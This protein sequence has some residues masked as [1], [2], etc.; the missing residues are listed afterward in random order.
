VDILEV[1][2]RL[3]PHAR[4]SLSMAA[5]GNRYEHLRTI[6][7][8]PVSFLPLS[9]DN[10]MRGETFG[11]EGWAKWQVTSWWR[12]SPGGRVLHKELDFAPD[13]SRLVGL[14]QAGNDPKWQALLGSAMDLGAT[15]RLDLQWRYVDE[16]PAPRLPSYLELNANLSWHATPT[17]DL[18][19]A[20]VNLLHSAH[21]EYP[22]PGGVSLR[23]ALLVQLKWQP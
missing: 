6:E 23:R 21:Q 3:R 10:L 12:L 1:G 13:A 2:L 18:G 16:L 19:L 20:G 17:L 7:P 9:W 4:F 22:A 15:W 14:S 11:I 5:F 8:T